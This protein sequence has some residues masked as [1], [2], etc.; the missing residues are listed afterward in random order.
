[1][2]LLLLFIA[3]YQSDFPRRRSRNLL[4]T[5]AHKKRKKISSKKVA[6]GVPK[7]TSTE[8]LKSDRLRAEVGSFMLNEPRRTI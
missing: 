4:Q 1:M 2:N 7:A 6:V 3:V 5:L 8:E